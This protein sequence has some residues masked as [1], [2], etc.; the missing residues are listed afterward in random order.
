MCD[1]VFFAEDWFGA[2]F[3]F[4][5]FPVLLDRIEFWAVRE[6]ANYFY[7]AGAEEL[8][9]FFGEMPSCII[10]DNAELFVVFVQSFEKCEEFPRINFWTNLCYH[11]S[12][13]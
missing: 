2:Q 5:I 12:D 8:F 4:D 3:L 10:D 6:K 13:S 9:Y 7:F 1:N 11:L